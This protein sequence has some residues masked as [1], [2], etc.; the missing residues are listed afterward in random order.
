[1]AEVLTE[2]GGVSPG[3]LWVVADAGV[4]SL[5]RALGEAVVRSAEIHSA[6]GTVDLWVYYT[7][8]AGTDGLH[9]GGE[10]LSMES[11][12]TAARVVP[13]EQRVFV[14]DAC[15]SGQFL[16]SKGATLVS[17][18]D[19]PADFVPPDDEAWIASAGA[20]ENAF[21][22][23][24]RRGAL[25]THFFVSGARGA[26]D[27]D[28]DG[29]ITLGELYGFVHARTAEEAAGLGQLQE[30]RWAGE[31]GDVV[32]SSVV[33]ATGVTT[34]GPVGRPLLLV[35]ERRGDVVAEIPSGAGARIALRPGRY[36]VVALGGD[37]S[38]VE[39]GSVVVPAEGWATTR[40]EALREVRGVRTRGGLVDLRSGGV[41]V[42]ALVSTGRSPGAVV[43]PGLFV[44]GRRAV[45][46]G[47]DLSAGGFVV[48][49]GVRSPTL[50]G[51]DTLL[52]VQGAARL[53]LL[54]GPLRLGPM[55]DAAAG[56][57]HQVVSRTADPVWGA[58]FGDDLGA[59]ARDV[60]WVATHAGVGLD[61]PLGPAAFL[62]SAGVGPALSTSRDLPVTTDATLRVGLEWA[63]P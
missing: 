47:V 32:V 2:L 21:E 34:D 25:F 39:V 3:D 11:L 53:D 7:G 54:P 41:A 13:A 12:K 29:Q 15:Q 4:G 5:T 14:V 43:G 6:G 9:L 18:A 24:A 31:L 37:R 45:G 30:P 17:V 46:R 44:E 62:V 28:D 38:R 1:V 50:S 23:D 27:Q 61:L 20:E 42:G 48:R 57:L 56:N 55:V 26:A 35:D 63:L 52:G 51:V 16:R 36:Q 10:V 40:S 33:D 59:T 58:W 22:V 8:H 49:A 60:G 19:A